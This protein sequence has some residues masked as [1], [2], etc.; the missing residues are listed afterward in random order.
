MKKTTKKL[1]LV[2]AIVPTFNL[3]DIFM[4]CLESIVKQ[5]YPNLEIIVIDN[6]ED[7]A[8]KLA[9]K[10]YPKITVKKS[11]ENLGSTGGMNAGLK[12]AKGDFIWFIDHDNIL[13]PDMLSIMVE[14]AQSKKN[15]GVVT[16]KILYFKPRNTIWSAGTSV[17]MIT[18]INYSREGKDVGQY[19]TVEEVEIAP[20]NFLV[21]RE[22]INKVGFYDDVYWVSYEDADW[23]ARVRKSGYKIIYTP[24]AICYH[25]I[26]FL[27][28]LTSK[29]RWLGRAY[30]T[31]RN[32]IIFMRKCSPYFL[33]FVLLYPVWFCLYTYQAIKYR[34][35][36]ALKNFYRGMFDGFKWAI[37]YRG[38]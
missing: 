31:A 36:S 20:A 14:L 18:G 23:C 24:H 21:K 11:S 37:S 4:E 7:G 5:D 38:Q 10:K 16:P 17:S 25:K 34:D 9:Q 27:D 33:L 13:N 2:S 3:K 35:F 28:K 8:Y 32:K 29:R 26:P 22:L 19:E 6:G 15:I 1:P 12:L 30:L